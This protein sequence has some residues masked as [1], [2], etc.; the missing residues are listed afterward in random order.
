MCIL[1]CLVLCILL[2]LALCILLCLALCI[3]LCLALCILFS[4]TIHLSHSIHLFP[5]PRCVLPPCVWL[6]FNRS[7]R[8][9]DE[10]RSVGLTARD[11]AQTQNPNGGQVR[12]RCVCVY[13]RSVHFVCV[14]SVFVL[15]ISLCVFHIVVVLTPLCRYRNVI[16]QY[17][18]L[19]L[20]EDTKQSQ[21]YWD[22]TMKVETHRFTHPL[23]FTLTHTF[24]HPL[25]CTLTH[26]TP[27]RV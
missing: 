23:T 3:L 25:T 7:P 2:C 4:H 1:L 11:N 10:E 15:C 18:N 26:H 14:F 27:P 9:C 20:V 16:V 22:C 6:H 5:S 24:T 13:S 21:D 19:V 8:T 12:A 17:L